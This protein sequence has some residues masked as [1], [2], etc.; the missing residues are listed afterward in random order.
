MTPLEQLRAKTLGRL[1]EY[2]PPRFRVFA[3][4]AYVAGWVSLGVLPLLG[5]VSRSRALAGWL[6]ELFG[7]LATLLRAGGHDTAEVWRLEKVAEHLAAQRS[8]GKTAMIMALTSAVLAVLFV[9]AA[10]A[11]FAVARDQ[12]LLWRIIVLGV[13][14]GGSWILLLYAAYGAAG[15]TLR[16]QYRLV[17]E[18]I[19][20]LSAVCKAS[21]LP[22]LTGP[23]PAEPITPPW[24]YLA[25]LTYLP[26]VWGVVMIR[27]SHRW[28]V[29]VGRTVRRMVDE[30]IEC[31]DSLVP[32]PDGDGTLVV[33]HEPAA[34]QKICPDPQCGA[35]NV[36][37]ATYCKRC[38]RQ[39]EES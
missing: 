16:T 29:H 18:A 3:P 31:F 35:A 27:Q 24:V 6:A 23:V 36:L 14:F 30:L 22:Q 19:G 34:D 25:A 20:H 9:P 4:V 38:G 1:D 12:S 37:E 11:L 28:S 33:R 15:N 10:I 17:D 7:D 32:E 8:H 13:V 2:R 39:L 21:D 26:T 5:I